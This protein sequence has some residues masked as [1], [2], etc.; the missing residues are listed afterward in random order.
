[1]AL[2]PT[3]QFRNDP[4]LQFAGYILHGDDYTER[5]RLRAHQL[6]F[7]DDLFNAFKRVRLIPDPFTI[8]T[9]LS[10]IA[11]RSM[12]EPLF[13]LMVPRLE[14]IEH[15]RHGRHERDIVLY[16]LALYLIE[17][18]PTI[19]N[20]QRFVDCSDG[21]RNSRADIQPYLDRAQ[22]YIEP[23][24][25]GRHWGR[26]IDAITESI[27]KSQEPRHQYYSPLPSFYQ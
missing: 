10:R 27:Q 20:A 24:L 25:M 2:P 4:L 12:L 23:Q 5:E 7:I 14:R 1:M 21:K 18:G 15:A 11:F 8:D 9:P 26:P 6:V 22:N 16:A 3:S 19:E 17:H 13:R